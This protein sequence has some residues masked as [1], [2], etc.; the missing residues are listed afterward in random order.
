MLLILGWKHFLC[1][2]PRADKF[3]LPI[4]FQNVEIFYLYLQNSKCF[5]WFLLWCFGFLKKKSGATYTLCHNEYVM[6]VIFWKS[7]FVKHQCNL[8]TCTYIIILDV[9]FKKRRMM[10]AKYCHQLFLFPSLKIYA[11]IIISVLLVLYKSL[12]GKFNTYGT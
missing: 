7:V 3:S 1:Q 5:F 12:V 2:F 6:L 10:R 11:P 4:Q 8:F 9:K